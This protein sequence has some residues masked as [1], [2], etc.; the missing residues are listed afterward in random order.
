MQ[1]LN[2]ARPAP[3]T[4][5][6]NNAR[7]GKRAQDIGVQERTVQKGHEFLGVVTVP[8]TAAIGQ[9]L[10]QLEVNPMNIP[11]LS[12]IASQYKQWK[13]P[14]T[15][16]VE[17]LGNAFATSSVSAAFVPDPDPTDLSQTGVD[18]LRVIDSAP[19]KTSLHLQESVTRNVT[20]SWALTTNPWKFLVDADPSDRANG[21]F[22][23]VALGSPGTIAI[24]LKIS[25]S[26]NI[27]FQGNTFLAMETA[28]AT[29]IS[30]ALGVNN[31]IANNAYTNPGG[32]V[33]WVYTPATFTLVFTYPTGQVPTK[34]YGLWT[35]AASTTW[36]AN[37]VAASPSVA[38]IVNRP[39]VLSINVTATQTTYVFSAALAVPPVATTTYT[40]NIRTRIAAS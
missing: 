30:A 33:T 29:P 36:F 37:A 21:L 8:T 3:S 1:A 11:R 15:L 13:G 19:A 22:V 10:Y 5:K 40:W 12:V 28:A 16:H 7:V 23:V 25:V 17:S 26:Y 35:Y 38:T 34:Y 2:I 18:L 39:T 4:R 14:M 6:R 9:N 31:N 20:A 27:T 24:D 32:L